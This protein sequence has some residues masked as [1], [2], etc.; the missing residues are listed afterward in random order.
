MTEP[1]VIRILESKP[2]NTNKIYLHNSENSTYIEFP[3]NVNKTLIKINSLNCGYT[4]MNVL[5]TAINKRR[6][7]NITEHI[8]SWESSSLKP[9]IYPICNAN[10]AF[11]KLLT[12]FFESICPSEIKESELDNLINFFAKCHHGYDV[13][14]II[15]CSQELK[16]V[17]T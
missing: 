11:A 14:S 9:S 16:P 4:A 15:K 5:A 7:E 6:L 8:R 2:E 17:I 3:E 12:I 1:K 13:S 10:K